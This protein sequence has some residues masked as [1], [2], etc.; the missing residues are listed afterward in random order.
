MKLVSFTVVKY[1]SIIKARRIHTGRSTILIGPNNE[2]KSNILRALVAAMS[3]L[4]RGA[5][6]VFSGN[7]LTGKFRHVG[8]YDW[9]HDFPT[10]LRER[11]PSGQ[12]VVELEFQLT[13]EETEAFVRDIKSSLNGTLPLRIAMG[14]DFTSVKV[15]KQ[16]RGAKSL[17]A[18][19]IAIAKFVAERLDFE[20]IPAIRTAESAQEVVELMV[21]RELE[22]LE[23]DNDYRLLLDSIAKLQ[24]PILDGVAES[25]KTT[26][27]KFLPAVRDVK[28]Q[29]SA[30]RRATA[31]RRSCEIYVND[32]ATTLLEYK[33]DGVQS[34]AALALMRHASDKRGSAR[35]LVVAIE[36]PESHL[37]PRAIH[38]LKAVLDE[39]SLRHQVVLTTHCPLFADRVDVQQNVVVSRGHASPA[40]SI[41]DVRDVLGVRAS[42]NMRH[43]ELV[44]VVEGA[45]DKDML[46]AV[47]EA[48][49]GPLGAA[50]RNA[51]IAVTTLA[52]GSKLSYELSILRGALV[53]Y[54]CFLDN[55]QTGRA[56]ILDAKTTG[57][58]TDADYHLASCPNMTNSELE[59]L[60]DVQVYRTAIENAYR[61][62]LMV[63]QFRSSNAKWSDRVKRVFESQG[64]IWDDRTEVAVKTMVADCVRANPGQA[65]H[66]ARR[67]SFDALTSAVETRLG[68]LR[69]SRE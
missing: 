52:G 40:K 46:T 41:Q 2:G 23:T 39:L 33:G 13:E 60:L 22:R 51:T 27:R 11:E 59:D 10:H 45:T 1:R 25:M 65:L 68:E 17:T 5:R 37:H 55:D 16:G 43:A 38:E 48:A 7:R 9:D 47:W 54:H 36:E 53:L 28:L 15:A 49:N 58:V 61:V 29:I 67:A 62:T 30:E 32:G 56:A 34:L 66:A 3:T 12:S 64:K 50:L 57:L 19:S 18:K 24:Q 21:G 44:V 20:H 31:L 8:F 69:K 6:F 63:P 42:D 35:N 14:R 4:T 26:L